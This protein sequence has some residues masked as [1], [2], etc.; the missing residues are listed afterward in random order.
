MLA[1]LADTIAAPTVATL[2]HNAPSVASSPFDLRTQKTGRGRNR[3]PDADP[4]TP[5]GR[6]TKRTSWGSRGSP[7]SHPKDNP[8]QEVLH[9]TG[10]ETKRA[11]WGSR[12][13]PTGCPKDSP[14]QEVLNPNGIDPPYEPQRMVNQNGLD[15]P[16]Q[17][18]KVVNP[19]GL[20]PPDQLKPKEEVDLVA[21][22]GT[23]G[24]QNRVVNS[25]LSVPEYG[26]CKVKKLFPR[27]L[28]E[29]MSEMC[30]W[31]RSLT[32]QRRSQSFQRRYTGVL[33]LNQG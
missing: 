33:F 8:P 22:E 3:R 5:R 11:S 29:Q 9:S 25:P 13:C 4:R 20:D 15:P 30:Q 27:T 31:M 26:M 7:A 1:R 23:T 2:F 28:S 19:N 10:Q 6:A 17:L 32:L 14:A 18:R 16:R 12:S 24:M 21:S